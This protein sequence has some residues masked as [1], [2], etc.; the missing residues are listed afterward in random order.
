MTAGLNTGALVLINILMITPLLLN[1][2]K[3]YYH[4][5]M[6]RIKFNATPCQLQMILTY[7]KLSIH[8]RCLVAKQS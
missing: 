6:I 5:A 1:H 4:V 8:F 2:G 7:T 3:I